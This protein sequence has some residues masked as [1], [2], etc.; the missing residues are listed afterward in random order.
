M[1]QKQEREN[2]DCHRNPLKM[3]NRLK[4]FNDLR[5]D[6]GD[7]TPSKIQTPLMVPNIT[8]KHH[9]TW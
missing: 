1:S 3:V 7:S 4:D 5:K 9:L 6:L 8:S 2:V